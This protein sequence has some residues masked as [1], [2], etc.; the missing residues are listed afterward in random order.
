MTIDT[1]L[2]AVEELIHVA[3]DGRFHELVDG[4]LITMSPANERHGRVTQRIAIRLGGYVWDRRLGQTYSS[5]TGYVLRRRPDTVRCPDASFLRKDR[6]RNGDGF[7]EGAP[8]LAVEVMSPSDTWAAVDRKVRDYL[9][10]GTGMV[11]VVDPRQEI[12]VEHTPAGTRRLTIEDSLDGGDVVPGWHLPLR[13]VFS[14]D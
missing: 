3:D 1:K 7:I 9:A 10:A 12:A 11:I 14:A 6:P 8:D 13:E 4:E 5:E 2:M